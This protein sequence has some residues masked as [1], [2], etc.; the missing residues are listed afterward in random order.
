MCRLYR[1]PLLLL[2]GAL[3][4]CLVDVGCSTGCDTIYCSDGL[5]L[6]VGPSSGDSLPPGEYGAKVNADGAEESWTCTLTEVEGKCTLVG[7][8]PLGTLRI[9]R[10]MIW[11][12]SA[13]P[14]HVTLSVSFEGATR[15]VE[16]SPQYNRHGTE[17]CGVCWSARE[18]LT[19]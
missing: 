10:V 2:I 16:V 11:E 15:S 6:E 19:L 9:G 18:T 12:T 7:G 4:A 3:Q 17:E 14:A 5:H 8:K 1:T 13:R